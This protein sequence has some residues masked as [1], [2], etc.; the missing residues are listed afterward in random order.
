MASASVQLL[1]LKYCTPRTT[2]HYTT[3]TRGTRSGVFFVWDVRF[4][5]VDFSRAARK[6]GNPSVTA[7]MKD[8]ACSYIRAKVT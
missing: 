3:L 4:L 8:T 6:H 5:Q 2:L 1:R 7:S